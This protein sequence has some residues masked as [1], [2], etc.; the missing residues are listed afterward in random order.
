MLFWFIFGEN[1]CDEK[2]PSN[3]YE[4]SE[5]LRLNVFV[6]FTIGEV[7]LVMFVVNLMRWKQFFDGRIKKVFDTL[8]QYKKKHLLKLGLN[9][10]SI[11]EGSNGKTS[12]LINSP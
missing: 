6:F 4:M 5:G 3:C 2:K 10:S 7:V 9:V 12:D 8:Y 11:S 1:S